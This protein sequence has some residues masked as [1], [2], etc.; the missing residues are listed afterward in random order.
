MAVPSA[1]KFFDGK[2]VV[3]FACGLQ[4]T[5]AITEDGKC[6][7][8]GFGGY[9]RLGHRVQQDELTP[10]E[11]LDIS[12]GNRQAR[13]HTTKDS[14]LAAGATSTLTTT[15]PVGQLY[16]WGKL[17]VNGDNLMY[18]TYMDHLQGWKLRDMACG[19]S[20]FVVAAENS[21]ISWGH[22]LYQELGYGEGGKKS[23]ANPCKVDIF[24]NVSVH[25]VGAGFANTMY[26]I[27]E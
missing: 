9:G 5:I 20:T 12:W 10:R 24:E 2:K 25:K 11:V 7:T 22:A 3:N 1:I 15:S 21:V 8:W 27:G 6:Y 4:H 19:H 13:M 26:I 17:K 23:S 16:A 14:L 18:P